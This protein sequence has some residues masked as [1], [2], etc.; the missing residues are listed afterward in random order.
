[1]QVQCSYGGAVYSSAFK[2]PSC[3]S[4]VIILH[5]YP[6]RYNKLVAISFLKNRIL[7]EIMMYGQIPYSTVIKFLCHVVLGVRHA[8]MDADHEPRIS[9]DDQW[10]IAHRH[11]S[12]L[13]QPT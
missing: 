8:R 4:G 2:H 12:S 1:M 7:V 5:G 6:L 3:N 11:A 10:P 9:F 13:Q